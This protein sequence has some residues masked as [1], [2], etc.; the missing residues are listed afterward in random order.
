MKIDVCISEVIKERDKA[1]FSLLMIDYLQN[2]CLEVRLLFYLV[3][4]LLI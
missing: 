2:R 1:L 3:N 4:T